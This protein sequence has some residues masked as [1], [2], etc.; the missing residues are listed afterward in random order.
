MLRSASIASGA[1]SASRLFSAFAIFF[2]GAIILKVDKGGSGGAQWAYSQ[3]VF[4]QIN[5]TRLLNETLSPFDAVGEGLH[6]EEERSMRGG[7]SKKMFA[8]GATRLAG[9]SFAGLLLAGTA[10]AEQDDVGYEQIAE[11]PKAEKSILVAKGAIAEAEPTAAPAKTRKRRRLEPIANISQYEPDLAEPRK[12][13]ITETDLT[14]E[15][16]S[17]PENDRHPLISDLAEEAEDIETELSIESTDEELS[18][19]GLVGLEAVT[20][21]GITPGVSLRSEVLA[22]WG[23]PESGDTQGETLHYQFEGLR[24]VDATFEKDRVKSIAIILEKPLPTSEM[25]ASLEL[26]ECRPVTVSDA[27][28]SQFAH[29]YPERGVVLT[30]S[31]TAGMVVASDE[32]TD[33]LE[34]QVSDVLLETINP[35]AFLLRA[36]ETARAN[37][38]QSIADLEQVVMMDRNSAEA[39]RRLADYYLSV[40]KA[41]TAERYAAE[42]VDLEP[43][44][45]PNRLQWAKCL[46]QL[47]R[48]DQAVDQA[49]QVLEGSGVKPMDK[50]RALEEMAQLASLGSNDVAQ[51]AIPLHTKAIEIADKLANSEN[52]ESRHAAQCLLIDAHLAIAMQIAQGNFQDKNRA[53]PQWLE[54]ASGLAE[55]LIAED[56]IYLPRRLQV[57]VSGLAAATNLDKPIDPKL[58]IEESEETVRL[59]EEA[60]TDRLTCSQFDWQLGMAYLHAADIEHVR[61]QAAS[62]KRFGELA[63]EKLSEL[64][65]QRDELP[66][67]GYTMGR[68]YFQI[69]AVYAIHE[70]DHEAACKWYHQAADLLLNPVPVT[71]L[72]VPQQ[73]GDAL[74]SMGVS[75]WRTN[76]RERAVELTLAGV[77][78]IEQAVDAGL[79]GST[80]LAIPYENLSAMYQALG[81]DEPAARYQLLARKLG[82]GEGLESSRR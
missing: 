62:A 46:S 33:T 28:K 15:R 65:R 78:L 38:S 11:R 49:K 55:A 5:P 4:D 44:H 29:V 26:E 47:A 76:E 35:A 32:E 13:G 43:D 79:L 58:W 56:S 63:E 30:V 25:I 7:Y 31:S 54:R 60:I 48:Y 45:H 39:R 81:K 68:L 70:D 64:S 53:V 12:T 21:H 20:F 73:H 75:Y 37:L 16:I 41:I 1:F 3:V 77:D 6:A 22:D 23:T 82:S 50:A 69:G 27:K 57:A 24:S 14:P 59:L 80:S 19:E 10:F 42:A 9:L 72:A 34:E 52:T 61:S 8:N 40:G 18:V 71:T 17:Q 67:T 74:V 2:A 66:D 51:K 36:K